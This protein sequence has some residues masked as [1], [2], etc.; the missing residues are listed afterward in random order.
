MVLLAD[1]A[2]LTTGRTMDSGRTEDPGRTQNQGLSTQDQRRAT[3][4]VVQAHSANSGRTRTAIAPHLRP[5]SPC[6]NRRPSVAAVMPL[7]TD[8]KTS[9]AWKRSRGSPKHARVALHFHPD[10]RGNTRARV[11]EGLL[12]DGVYRNQDRDG[13]LDGKPHSIFRWRARQ[14]GENQDEAGCRRRMVRDSVS[15]A[16]ADAQL[17]MT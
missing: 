14:L 16:T 15:H 8:A 12:A 9:A 5:A 3:V 11:A 13:A 2:S 1:R 17:M 10:R 7:P 6:R 4:R